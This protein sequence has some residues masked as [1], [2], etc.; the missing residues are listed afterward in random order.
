MNIERLVRRNIV[1]LKPYRSARQDHLD[2]ILLDANEN[3]YG[4]PVTFNG[5]QLNRYPDPNQLI[6]RRRLADINNVA[7]DKIFVGSGSDEVIDLMYRIFC[8]PGSDNVIIPEPTYGMYRVSAAIHNVSVR[9]SILTDE[10]QLDVQEILQRVNDSTKI[11]F[12]CSPN[13]PTGNMFSRKDLLQLCASTE[14]LIV[15]DEAYIEFAGSTS[16]AEYIETHPNLVVMRTLSKS[17]G[18]AG[19]RLG[20][21]IAHPAIIE[22]MQKVKAPYNVNSVSANLALT[23]L[24][25]INDRQTIVEVIRRERKRLMS[26]LNSLHC[27]R[28]VFPSDANFFLVRV[29]DAATLYLK[30]IEKGIVIRDRSSEPKLENCVRITVGTPEENN[31]LITALEEFDI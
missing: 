1:R 16:I 29:D 22:F 3:A 5:V 6:L 24:N 23:A 26:H 12:C 17:W 14:A 27:V 8:E 13:N 19:I 21:C 10:F 31:A 30:L 11:I 2:G 18:L 28:R 15:V 4:S 20:Y 7:V 9:A 25:A